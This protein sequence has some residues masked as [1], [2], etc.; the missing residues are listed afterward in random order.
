MHSFD[1]GDLPDEL[2]TFIDALDPGENAII[3]RDGRPIA[4]VS[5]AGSK[6]HARNADP[7]RRAGERSASTV[8]DVKVVATAMELSSSARSSLSEQ[9]GPD[10]IVLDINSAPKSAD[11]LLTPPLSPQLIGIFRSMFPKARVVIAEVEDRALGVSYPGPVRRLLDAGADIY[12]PPS[13]IPHLA[14]LLDHDV[15]RVNLLAGNASTPP[16]IE[17]PQDNKAIEG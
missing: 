13:T 15:N 7:G 5:R 16:T 14:K 10:Y 11:V 2:M 4:S 9:L 17:A 1:A 3:T 6:F 8:E 12:F